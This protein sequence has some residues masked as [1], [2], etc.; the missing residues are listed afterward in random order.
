MENGRLYVALACL[1][2]VILLTSVLG[3]RNSKFPA[4]ENSSA[5]ASKRIQR[6][7]RGERKLRTAREIE[8]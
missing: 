1:D 5:F 7:Q 2:N 6:E 8:D 4:N 3:L